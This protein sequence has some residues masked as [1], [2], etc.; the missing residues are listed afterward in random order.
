MIDSHTS[1]FFLAVLQ[2][3]TDRAAP[4]KY[5]NGVAPTNKEYKKKT[6]NCHL[7]QLWGDG[8]SRGHATRYMRLARG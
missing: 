2:K 8:V 6:R 3:V 7:F 5:V 4:L 1:R